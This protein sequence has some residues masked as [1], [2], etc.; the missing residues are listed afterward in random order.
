MHKSVVYIYILI[1][2]IL[3]SCNN[4]EEINQV[5]QATPEQQEQQRDS[6]VKSDKE[7]ADSML[8]AMQKKLNQQ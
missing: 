5:N 8:K 4:T 3:Y 7:R 1:A 6:L 2:G